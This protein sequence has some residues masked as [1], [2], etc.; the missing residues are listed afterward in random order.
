MGGRKCPVKIGL[1]KLH[2]E[3]KLLEVR[4]KKKIN[5]NFLENKSTANLSV[6]LWFYTFLLIIRRFLVKR[7]FNNNLLMLNI[8]KM[9]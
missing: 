9:S 8:V 4:N 2:H 5:T 6:D 7:F 3:N 1:L